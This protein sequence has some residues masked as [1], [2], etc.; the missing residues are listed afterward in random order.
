[1]ATT[2]NPGTTPSRPQ[3]ASARALFPVDSDTHLLDRLNAIY[4]YR[5][6]VITVFLLVMLSAVVR[7]Y[8]TTPMY[9]ATASLLIEDDRGKTVAGFAPQ[10]GGEFLD[11]EP[12]YQTQ[13]RILT[14]RELAA[15]AVKRLQSEGVS[16]SQTPDLSGL[17]ATFAAIRAQAAGLMGRGRADTPAAPPTEE[18]LIGRFLGSVV[19][20]PVMGSQIYNVSVNSLSADYSARAANALAE[21]YAKQNFEVRTAATAKSL[22]FLGDEIRKQQKKVEDSERAMAQ[23]RETNNALSLEDRQNTVVSSLNQVNEQYTRART[24]RIQKEAVY[25]QVKSL[26]SDALA[27]SVPAVTQNP[28][29]QNLRQ[30]LADLQRERV[31]LSDRYGDKHPQVIQNANAIEDASKQYPGGAQR[32]GLLDSQRL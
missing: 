4:K 3:T 19:V 24:E 6:I 13:L 9:R 11:P 17:A 22:E 20:E 27:E 1:M 25:N 10:T 14:G 15:K 7:T 2:V 26:P 23:Y 8:T 29:V 5:Y 12:Y 18:E 28:A 21:E 31:T 16:D 30:R 32:R